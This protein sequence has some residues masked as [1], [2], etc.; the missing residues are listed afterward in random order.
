MPH[1]NARFRWCCCRRR[2][3]LRR[4]LVRQLDGVG[5]QVEEAATVEA[6]LEKTLARRPAVI[7]VDLYY[8]PFR[9]RLRLCETLQLD[10]ASRSVPVVWLARLDDD[11]A[12]LPSRL[13]SQC[14][15]GR[16]LQIW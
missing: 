12:E 4:P 13:D 5:Y 8:V 1:R 6:A 2:L 10:P 16:L 14:A 9:E 15:Q 3:R 7:L 11:V